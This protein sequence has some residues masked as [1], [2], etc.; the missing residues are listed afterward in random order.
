MTRARSSQPAIE[1]LS[2]SRLV[3]VKVPD[4]VTAVE[5]RRS[6]RRR[7]TVAARLEGDI[8]VVQL[9][10]GLSERQED[11]YVASL[12]GRITA[13]RATRDVTD[14]TLGQRAEQ[15]A[16]RYLDGPA[17]RPLRPT[18]VNWVTNMNHRWG[19]CS[20]DSG[21]IRLSHRLQAMP[22]WV[23]DYVLIHELTHLAVTGH[24][25][26]F[27]HLV[28]NYPRAERAMGFLQGWSRAGGLTIGENGVDEDDGRRSGTGHGD[29]G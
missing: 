4:G 24:G 22:G 19:S 3:D 10:A 26:G 15:L 8:A 29:A 13:R 27:W 9:P 5:L 7:K 6:L 18:S 2:P 17:G 11:E 23:V 1:R 20:T 14:E 12:L 16:E 21:R 25:P 28:A